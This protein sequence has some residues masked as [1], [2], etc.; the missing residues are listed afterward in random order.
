MG[1]GCWCWAMAA[2]CDR[3]GY[4]AIRVTEVAAVTGWLVGS[5]TRRN[6]KSI[7]LDCRRASV[8]RWYADDCDVRYLQSGVGVGA[9]LASVPTGASRSVEKAGAENDSNAQRNTDDVDPKLV[10]VR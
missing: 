10:H 5:K 3:D 2:S 4:N 1:D 9:R 7:R 8:T 6:A